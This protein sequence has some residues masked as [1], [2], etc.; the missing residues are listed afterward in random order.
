MFQDFKNVFGRG[1]AALYLHTSP[2][3]QF[4]V[5]MT[6]S[7]ESWLEDYVNKLR[8]RMYLI[9]KG[10]I[11]YFVNV[12]NMVKESSTFR[13]GSLTQG[14][15]IEVQAQGKFEMLQSSIYPKRC[16]VPSEFF[17]IVKI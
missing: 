5:Y 4:Y 14:N 16:G 1:H 8:N 10:N 11:S 17:F 6:K 7:I 3:K 15:G 13:N 12:R 2:H 9:Q